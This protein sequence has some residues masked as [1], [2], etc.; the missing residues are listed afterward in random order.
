MQPAVRGLTD[1][2]LILP[3]SEKIEI[4]VG[5]FYFTIFT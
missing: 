5:F 4:P 3:V 2:G 1:P